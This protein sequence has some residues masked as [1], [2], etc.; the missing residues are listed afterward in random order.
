MI[1]IE[2]RRK[3]NFP[4]ETHITLGSFDGLH[5]GHM[6][7]INETI[8]NSRKKGY[9]SMVYTFKNHPITVL[10][11]NIC[12]KLLMDNENKI[13]CLSKLGVDILSL[14]PFDNS[15]MNINP[16]TFVKQLIKEY[17]AKEIT[18]GFN[19]KFGKEN[20]G[21]V[22]LLKELQNK[23]SFK[24]HVI[25]PIKRE[26][27]IV[28]STFIRELIEIGEIEKANSLLYTCFSLK[29]N[30]VGGKRFGRQMGFPTA[31]LNFSSNMIVPKTGVYY[32]KVKYNK[33]IYKGITNIGY[34]PTVDGKHFTVE[35][36]IL[37]FNKMIYGED[38]RLYF[39]KR[40]RDEHKF[41]SLN[42]LKEQLDRDKSFAINEQ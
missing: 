15:F 39:I 40:I 3:S 38:L 2:D 21:N 27:E 30:I 42:E 7:L 18:V 25:G 16:E 24:L 32:T 22:E 35:T 28:S 14:I 19:F 31:N 34:S 5:L 13:N 11:K 29:G 1:I 41:A 23:F 6:E 12:P 17:G 36:N 20:K 37:N 9:K 26:N 4:Y 10:N 33:Q 8:K